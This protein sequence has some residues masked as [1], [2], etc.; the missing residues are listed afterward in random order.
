MRQ[1]PL[2]TPDTGEIVLRFAMD[3]RL[4]HR[5]LRAWWRTA[6]RPPSFLRRVVVWALAWAAILPLTVGLGVIGVPPAMVGAG[7]IGAGVLILGFAV[8]QRVRMRAFIDEL[9]RHW[10]LAGETRAIFGPAGVRLA[11]S[12]SRVDLAWGAVDGIGPG[13]GLTVLRVGVGMIAIP[14]AALP[15]GLAPDAFRAR[16]DDWRQVALGPARPPMAGQA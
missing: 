6:L 16:L 12:V 2:A 15:A 8:L 5:G 1:E 10:Q 7:V 9:A 11:D 13:R 4:L 14:D 3:G